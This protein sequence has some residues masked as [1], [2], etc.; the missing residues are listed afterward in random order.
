M[1]QLVLDPAFM[2]T[3]PSIQSFSVPPT[4]HQFQ[5]QIRSPLSQYDDG[6]VTLTKMINGP[7]GMRGISF[8]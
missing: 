8:G 7:V 5:E 2:K 6:R 4:Y 3:G 1:N